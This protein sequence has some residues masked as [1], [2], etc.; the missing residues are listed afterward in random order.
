MALRPRPYQIQEGV[1]IKH[2][3]LELKFRISETVNAS[4]F[5]VSL[6]QTD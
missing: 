6:D 3:Y 2:R 4:G 1:V 5:I